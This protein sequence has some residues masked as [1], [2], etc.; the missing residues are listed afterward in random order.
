MNC[1]KYINLLFSGTSDFIKYAS[2]TV[3][4]ALENLEENVGI[5]VYFLYAD[6]L[7]PISDI[8][9]NDW[10]EQIS[11][12]FKD[13][14]VNFNFINVIDKLNLLKNLNIGLWGREV[15]LTH[16]I[17]YLAPLVMTDVDKVIHIDCDF[18]VNCNL[19]EIFD[20]DLG[21]KLIVLAAQNGVE[22]DIE[23]H[24]G[25]FSILNLKQWRKENTF[26]D[27]INFGENLPKSKFCDTYLINEYF[28]K[29]HPDR[30]LVIDKTYNLFPLS[31]PD[32]K[33]EEI[34]NLH[35]TGP[36]LK[37]WLDLWC[38]CRGSFLWWQYA[39]KTTFYESF[40]FDNM[41]NLRYQSE[42]YIQK[43]INEIEKRINEYIN[44][45][46]IKYLFVTRPVHTLLAIQ[47]ALFDEL[48]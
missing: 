20:I 36:N 39:R 46:S 31:H 48:N 44:K 43:R 18:I 12:S 38:I 22:E 29:K 26:S 24:N 10:I 4:S 33:I 27:I 25:G 5:N 6:I 30:L 45:F 2:V 14:N 34:K 19:C 8:T 1:K 15:S 16:Y 7:K 40:I 47:L 23:N 32:L 41:L 11:Y 42:N 17:H 21:E 13:K 35:F 37:P 9:R 28:R 3:V